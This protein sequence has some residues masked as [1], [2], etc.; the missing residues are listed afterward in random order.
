MIDA[1]ETTLLLCASYMERR[2]TAQL[3][4]LGPL[5]WLST[6]MMPYFRLGSNFAPAAPCQGFSSTGYI[7]VVE[8]KHHD[9]T[10]SDDTDIIDKVDRK[11]QRHVTISPS[12]IRYNIKRH[13][14]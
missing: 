13:R 1:G 2:E 12:H 6:E 8:A 4:M 7:S 10:G 14:R 11:Q 5:E 9:E 3:A